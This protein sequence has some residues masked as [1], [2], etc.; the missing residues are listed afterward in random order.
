VILV[1]S[2][3]MQTTTSAKV[4]QQPDQMFAKG[5]MISTFAS[6]S[7]HGEALASPLLTGQGFGK[8]ETEE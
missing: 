8:A 6:I 1:A 2:L 3:V 7:C 5:G 4:K